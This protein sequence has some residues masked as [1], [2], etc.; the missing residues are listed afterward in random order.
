M[1]PV[2]HTERA[3]G[4]IGATS[5]AGAGGEWGGT[6]AAFSVAGYFPSTGVR[7]AA[8]PFPANRPLMTAAIAPADQLRALREGCGVLAPP[9]GFV[10]VDGADAEALLQNLL[11]QDVAGM[12]DGEARRA[13]LLTPKARVVADARVVRLGDTRYLLDVEPVAAAD[14]VTQLLR[15]RLAAKAEIAVADQWSLVS[16]IGPGAPALDL[17]GTR[18]ATS[19]GDLPRVD[20]I[21]PTADLAGSLGAAERDGATPVEEA[22]V[23]ALRVAAGEVR[24]GRD[25]DERWM[26]A[27]VGLVDDAVSFE[28]G[29][30][31]GQEPVPRLHRRGHAN[32]GPRRLASAEPLAAGAVLSADGREVGV[33]TSAAGPP[34]LDAPRAIG[35]VRVDVEEPISADGIPVELLP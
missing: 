30:F 23:E 26:P 33:V 10:A 12:A 27:E 18:I 28:K 7:A 19:L 20:V 15:Y 21:V 14:L 35:I 9:R 34:W 5:I 11:T 25:V 3:G 6:M 32:R 29:C 24:L 17:P 8:R 4:R 16:L 1:R 22:A 2:V 13:L 31:I